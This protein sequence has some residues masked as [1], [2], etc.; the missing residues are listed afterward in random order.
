[1]FGPKHEPA[2]I[3]L[4]TK[5]PLCI[6]RPGATLNIFRL[7]TVPDGS[8]RRMPMLDVCTVTDREMFD[9]IGRGESAVDVMEEHQTGI[10]F[11][12]PDGF[13]LAWRMARQIAG[14]RLLPSSFHSGAVFDV[15]RD[16]GSLLLVVDPSAHHI[17]EVA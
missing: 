16:D 15:V 12:S 5:E 4:I 3:G 13:R 1:M 10:F 8:G 7:Q 14:G 2:C 11:T 17:E 9:R 6:L